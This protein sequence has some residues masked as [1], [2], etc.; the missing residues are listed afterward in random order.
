MKKN[1]YFLLLEG[2]LAILA[3][4]LGVMIFNSYDD[5]A[6]GKI[7]VI[8]P[9]SDSNRW[10][11][12]KYGLKMAAKD[13]KI[14]L[15]IVNTDEN[16]T[17]KEQVKFLK[18]AI[19]QGADG[20]IVQPVVGIKAKQLAQIQEQL[21]LLV[22]GT[23]IGNNE[24]SHQWDNVLPDNYGLGKTLG[25]EVLSDYGGDL[26]GKTIGVLSE[27][28]QTKAEKARL[29]GFEDAIK[30]AGAATLWQVTLS[31]K[32]SIESVDWLNSL[33]NVNLVVALDDESVATT[34]DKLKRSVVYGIGHSTESMHALDNGN[35]EAL[36]VP[37]LFQ[38]GYESVVNLTGELTHF[39]ASTKQET[40]DYQVIRQEDLFSKENQELLF[41]MSQN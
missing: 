32:A 18:Q 19:A 13:Q 26:K 3:V 11:S 35:V 25:E 24:E 34:A 23:E 20:L 17:A 41:T 10:A 2:L 9:D 15:V 27:N 29:Q 39:F 7:A 14:D 33:A 4:I 40:I 5:S 31:E 8:L 16:L 36:V 38:M 6:V 1:K 12:L 30:T 21:P 22:V 37:D 28:K